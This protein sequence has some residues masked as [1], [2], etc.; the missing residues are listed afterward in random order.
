MVKM[1]FTIKIR[2][3][4]DK[5][6]H[7]LWDDT[8][9]RDWA[10]NIDEGLYLA[11]EIREGNEVQWISSVNGYGVTSLVEKLVPNEFVLFRHMADTQE[12]GTQ[13]REKE[14]AGGAESYSLAEKDDVT[15]LTI[16]IDVPPGQ[17]ETFQGIVPKALERVKTLTKSKLL[18]MDHIGIV[19]ES[20]DTAFF[21]SPNWV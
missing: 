18:R 8:T 12:S 20:L 5:V 1:Q 16:A 7:T 6:W 4:K 17:T 2:A 13:E 15:V 21:F 19:V 11:G 14:W 9:F 10:K 3:Q